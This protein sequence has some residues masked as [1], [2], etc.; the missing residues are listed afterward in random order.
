MKPFRKIFWQSHSSEISKAF[1]LQYQIIKEAG[2]VEDLHC[3]DVFF[4]RWV[5]SVCWLSKNA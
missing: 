3:I 1:G 4:W 5:Q 2:R